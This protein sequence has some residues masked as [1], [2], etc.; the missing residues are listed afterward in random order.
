MAKRGL[1]PSY[2]AYFDAI[3]VITHLENDFEIFENFDF[4]ENSGSVT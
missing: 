4:F 3:E 1:K 2:Y